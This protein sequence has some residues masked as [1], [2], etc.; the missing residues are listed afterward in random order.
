[1]QSHGIPVQSLRDLRFRHRS[2]EAD[3]RRLAR[4]GAAQAAAPASP[5][6]RSTSRRETRLGS[7]VHLRFVWMASPRLA[8]VGRR[9]KRTQ[10]LR[11][12]S[13]DSHGVEPV[14][15]NPDSEDTRLVA[16]AGGLLGL[17]IFLDLMEAR[18]VLSLDRARVGRSCSRRA[19]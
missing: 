16:G 11:A 5:M 15:Q 14:A 1:M 3:A 17:V 18:W 13:G 19:P 6:L 10:S 12:A 4:T 9:R 7:T 8:R 2:T